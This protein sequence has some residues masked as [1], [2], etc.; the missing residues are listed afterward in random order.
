MDHVPSKAGPAWS[1][2][3]VRFVLVGPQSPGNIGAAC[4]ALKNLG[5]ARL[6]LVSPE[7]DPRAEEG[8]RFAVDARDLLEG[9]L[10]HAR[11]DDALAGAA[12]VVGTTGLSGKQRRPHFRL[13]AFGPELARLAHAGQVALVFGR[14]SRGLTDEELDRCTH[15]VHLPAAGAYSSYNLAQAV[16]LVG[17]TLRLAQD[18]PADAAALEPPAP[19]EEREAMY[20]HLAEA[21]FA[22][23]FLKDD[24]AEGMMRRLRRMLG[25]AA[26][27]SGEVKI[28]R[29][30]ARQI[31]WLS[32]RR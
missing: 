31:L 10:V 6:D 22:I 13:D 11:L 5:F 16:L 26:V 32:G 30:I 23:G 3:G 9:A 15:L 19:H 29:G 27:S 25:R 28:V 21:L 24:Q 12:T 4:R 17:Y 8:Y 18:L 20:A 7:C 1:A 2:N 14:E